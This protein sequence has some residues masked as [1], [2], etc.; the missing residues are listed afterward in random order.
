M[1]KISLMGIGMFAWA[2]CAVALPL[3]LA[4][5]DNDGK[6]TLCHVPPGNAGN[7]QTL[8]VAASAVDSHLNEHAGDH[9]G[10]CGDDKDKSEGKDKSEDKDKSGKSSSAKTGSVCVSLVLL[11]ESIGKDKTKED[12]RAKDEHDKKDSEYKAKAD[13]DDYTSKAVDDGDNVAKNDHESKAKDH[14]DKAKDH[15][16][17]AKDHEDKS[18]SYADTRTNVESLQGNCQA[19]NSDGTGTE[20][21][22]WIPGTPDYVS[23]TLAQDGGA[24][25][26]ID[27]ISNDGGVTVDSQAEDAA[28]ESY[29]E[30]RGE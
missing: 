21:G 20:P 1:K 23:S 26:L 19:V 4:Y 24:S 15:E 27:S 12:D 22:V 13:E 18:K 9:L 6:V 28:M 14:E 5:A 7:P 17:K 2:L 16:G 10:A 3:D 11:T 25:I 29:R 8:S 30:I